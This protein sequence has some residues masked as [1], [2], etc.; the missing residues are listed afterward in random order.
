M[1]FFLTLTVRGEDLSI[2]WILS[3]KKYEG[4]RLISEKTE[5]LCAELNKRVKAATG[6]YAVTGD[7]L[8]DIYFV[9]VTMNH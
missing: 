9:P 2:G 6:I 8:Q 1:I 4:T 5:V 3:E 7:P